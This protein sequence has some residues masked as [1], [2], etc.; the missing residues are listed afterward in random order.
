MKYCN[1][2]FISR[3]F[4]KCEGSEG[5]TFNSIKLLFNFLLFLG[6][7]YMVASGIPQEVIYFIIK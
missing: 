7:A 5:I 6:D 2:I 4:R 1:L 3:V